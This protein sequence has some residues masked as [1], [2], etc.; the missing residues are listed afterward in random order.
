M[1]DPIIIP[2]ATEA[3]WHAERAKAI[4]ASE[5]PDLCGVGFNTPFQLWH[6][7]KSGVGEVEETERM[8]AGKFLEAG[9][10][11]WYAFEHRECYKVLTPQEFYSGC[12][13]AFAVILRHPDLPMQCTPDRILVRADETEAAGVLQLKNTDAFV[14]KKLW[15]DDE[16]PLR[17]QAQVQAEML[18]TGLA[19]GAIG[20]IIGG[21]RRRDAE[22][23][24]M[25]DF[26]R[27]LGRLAEAFWLSL[28]RNQPPAVEAGDEATIKALFPKHAEGVELELDPSLRDKVLELELLKREVKARE[29][30]IARLKAE[31]ELAAGEAEYLTIDYRRVYSYKTTPG[32]RT[33]SYVTRDSRQ[34]KPLKDLK[35]LLPAEEI[36]PHEQPLI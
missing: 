28:E 34:L 12:S 19:F 8:R 1:P 24:A 10:A 14:E 3:D 6:R 23:R 2:C 21:N 13:G 18:C 31:L 16:P 26:Q 7:K 29:L 9:N 11:A 25:P 27:N 36:A 30:T 33:V 20:T 4:G 32:G 17:V 22:V 35:T 5:I 15:V